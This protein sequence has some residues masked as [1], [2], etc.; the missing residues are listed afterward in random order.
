SYANIGQYETAIERYQAAE[1]EAGTEH[2]YGDDARLRQAEAHLDLG[3][4]DKVTELLSTLP[5]RY[6]GGD[7]RAEAMWRLAWRDYKDGKLEEAIAWLK[8]QIEVMPI[9][10]NYWAEGQPQYWMGR[11]YD[12]LKRPAEAAA[13]YEQAVKL[14][15]LSYYALLALNRL[16]E[17]HPE[18]FAALRA[19]I[20]AQPDGWDPS[21]PAFRFKPRALYGSP[22]FKR[23]LE[24]MRLGLGVPAEAEL[25]RLG[26]AYPP[27][28]DRV[29]DPDLRDKLWAMAFL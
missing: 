21:Q 2:S 11:A 8:K 23:A 12:R 5:A 4:H 7:M 13:A 29:D 25:R 19:E 1:R 22:G 10:D 20:A 16:R 9:D 27:G 17:K 26:L 28:K 14:Y 18:R 15:P 6:P 24:L 3:N